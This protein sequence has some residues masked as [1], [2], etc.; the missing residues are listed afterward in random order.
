MHQKKKKLSKISGIWGGGV[1][2]LKPIDRVIALKAQ[3]P[4]LLQ[5]KQ[6]K[7]LQQ[8]LTKC[9]KI[10]QRQQKKINNKNFKLS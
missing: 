1:V 6:T 5:E 3:G 7:K 4:S 8:R 10:F 9:I 2:E